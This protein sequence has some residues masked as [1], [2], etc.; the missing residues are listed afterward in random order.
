MYIIVGIGRRRGK[1]LCP[2]GLSL[3]FLRNSYTENRL[4]ITK[5]QKINGQVEDNS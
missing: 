1:G 5:V 4:V 2:P 3:K